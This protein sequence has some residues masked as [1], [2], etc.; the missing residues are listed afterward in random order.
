MPPAP[1]QRVIQAYT[2]S[3]GENLNTLAQKFQVSA[4]QLQALNPGVNF[5]SI[6]PGE[7]V[8]VPALVPAQ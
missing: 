6:K 2:I 1:V 3:S 8:S 5:G 7:T 4:G